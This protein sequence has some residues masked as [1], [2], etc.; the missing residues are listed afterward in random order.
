M[1]W[2]GLATGAPS[3]GTAVDACPQAPASWRCLRGYARRWAGG[4]G[5]AAG[6]GVLVSGVL[7]RPAPLSAD[8]LRQAF[9]DFAAGFIDRAPN[10]IAAVGCLLLAIVAARMVKRAV[11]AALRRSPT[12]THLRVLAGKLAH[13]GVMVAGIVVA[14]A[15]A[16]ANLTALVASVGLVTV[17][18][19]V[20]L[21]DVVGNAAAG[22]LLLLEHPFTAGDLIAT[23]DA[24]GTVEDVRIQTTRLRA[25]D[26]QLVVVPNKLL[27]TSALT[28]ATATTRRRLE[29]AL[30]VS[31]LSDTTRLLQAVV[32]AASAVDGV[33][34]DPA[35]TVAV[36][37]PTPG[38][39]GAGTARFVLWC[40]VDPHSTDPE[41]VRSELAERP[42]PRSA[43]S[44]DRRPSRGPGATDDG[45]SG[46]AARP[47][48]CRP[49]G[50]P[51][52]APPR[53][54]FWPGCSTWSRRC[55]RASRP[56][57][58]LERAGS[59]GDPAGGAGGDGLPGAG[60]VLLAGG[61]RRRPHRLAPA[62]QRCGRGDH[63]ARN[64]MVDDH[65]D[66]PQWSAVAAGS[67]DAPCD[68]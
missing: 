43:G 3:T 63:Q 19:A 58:H 31:S 27:T 57:R 9:Q 44:R 62:F 32:D 22:I 52:A 1:H 11:E 21:Q 56:A 20:G 2:L 55:C 23:K 13:L 18:I 14:L 30:Q 8:R 65:H 15:I 17:A 34:D 68:D 10:L 66:A 6:L 4:G 7:A 50:P 48:P 61:R 47:L 45:R 53:P 5:Q 64:L 39:G 59:R 54:R 29:V 67:S 42:Q 41:R 38:D 28:N 49:P 46:P 35:A 33:A 26:G 36:Q 37:A 24:E 12:E 25:P 51:P 60:L 40:W 16:G